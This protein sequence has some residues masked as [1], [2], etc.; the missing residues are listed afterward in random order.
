R[1]QAQTES[2]P[3]AATCERTR[4]RV[5][6]DSALSFVAMRSASE[7]PNGV[8]FTVQHSVAAPRRTWPLSTELSI[9]VL[10][11]P[12]YIDGRRCGCLV[13]RIDIHRYKE[14][15]TDE[16][17]CDDGCAEGDAGGEGDVLPGPVVACLDPGGDGRRSAAGAVRL[18]T[19]HG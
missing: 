6:S 2:Q 16:H 8:P 1:A 18:R 9:D 13:C 4:S 3:W 14:L 5:G 7:T 11:T 15:R 17:Q 10:I 12:E 19:R